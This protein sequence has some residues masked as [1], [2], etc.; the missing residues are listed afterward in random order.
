MN[1]DKD[2]CLSLWK[3]Y[4]NRK[5]RHISQ[6]PVRLHS[7]FQSDNLIIEHYE[8][9]LYHHVF[10]V[11]SEKPVL[12]SASL[13]NLI[14]KV[15][16]RISLVQSSTEGVLDTAGAAMGNDVIYIPPCLIQRFPCGFVFILAG[17]FLFPP[18][19]VVDAE[20]RACGVELPQL[21][22]IVRIIR[23]QNAVPD[24]VAAGAAHGKY[25]LSADVIKLAPHQMQDAGAY[26]LYQAAVPLADWIV[27]EQIIVFMVSADEQRGKG[28]GLQPVQPLLLRIAAIPDTAEVAVIPNS[29]QRR[30]YR[31]NFYT[32]KFQNPV[33]KQILHKIFRYS[34][35]NPVYRGL[36]L[37][38][39]FSRVSQCL[40]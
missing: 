16:Q 19:P 40:R 34:I 38:S 28:P 10:V 21:S 26:G 36:A 39:C 4:L 31:V 11:V 27:A 29:G 20:Q 14:E 18:R 15:C 2:L 13:S 25:P 9:F 1:P 23:F 8:L 32:E 6:S 5:W 30:L 7:S 17:Q 12:E 24:I 33:N 35:F 3:T 22:L 37:H